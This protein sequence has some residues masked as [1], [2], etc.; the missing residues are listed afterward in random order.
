MYQ[1]VKNAF[2]ELNQRFAELKSVHAQ[3]IELLNESLCNPEARQNYR[4]LEEAWRTAYRNF[5]AA[6]D[7]F[8]AEMRS[9]RRRVFSSPLQLCSPSPNESTPVIAPLQ[10]TGSDAGA[11]RILALTE[12]DQTVNTD[13]SGPRY[14][15]RGSL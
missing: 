3:I 15:R 7:R 6:S 13:H 4:K 8:S 5:A 11:D 2:D 10:D 1:D 12:Y 9:L 14:T